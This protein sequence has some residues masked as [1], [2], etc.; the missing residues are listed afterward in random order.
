MAQKYENANFTAVM[1]EVDNASN[2]SSMVSCFNGADEVEIEELRR[3]RNVIFGD[4]AKLIAEYARVQL[5]DEDAF[6]TDSPDYDL[7]RLRWLR[8][9]V[10]YVRTAREYYE[11]GRISHD[12][13]TAAASAMT[14]IEKCWNKTKYF[15]QDNPYHVQPLPTKKDMLKPA[16]QTGE[17]RNI[18]DFSIATGTLAVIPPGKVPFPRTSSPNPPS[19]QLRV[20]EVAMQPL[21]APQQQHNVDEALQHGGKRDEAVQRWLNSTNPATPSA[22]VVPPTNIASTPTTSVGARR[23]LEA[24]RLR[25]QKE[26]E[27][28]RKERDELRQVVAKSQQQL[29]EQ[30]AV[31]EQATTA[32]VTAAANIAFEQEMAKREDADRKKAEEA[33]AALANAQIVANHAKQQADKVAHELAQ[34]EAHIQRQRA[35]L[36]QNENI[37]KLARADADMMRSNLQAAKSQAAIAKED[38]ENVRQLLGEKEKELEAER[39]VNAAQM[40]ILDAHGSMLPASTPANGHTSPKRFA[41]GPSPKKQGMHP[42]HEQLHRR[43]QSQQLPLIDLTKQTTTRSPHPTSSEKNGNN[44]QENATKTC[45]Y[46]SKSNFEYEDTFIRCKQLHVDQMRGARPS[47]PFSKGTPVDFSIH[48]KAFEKAT[49]YST[50]TDED[51]MDEMIH[52]FAGEAAKVVRL[53]QL[54]MN[55]QEAYKDVC[56]ELDS[57]FRETQDTFGTTI[58]AITR[59]KPIDS[60]DYSNHLALYTQLREAQSVVMTAGSGF[61]ANEFNRRDVIREILNA[62]LPHLTDRFWREDEKSKRTTGRSFAFQDLLNELQQWLAILRAKNPEGYEAANAKKAVIAAISSAP[63]PASTPTYAKRLVESPPK[64]QQTTKCNECGGLHETSSC[65]VL[66]AMSVEQRVE[67]LSRRGLCFHCMNPGHRASSCTQRPTCQKCSRKH[68]TMLHDRKFE[69]P[70]KKTSMSA[71][72]LP[73]QPF[74]SNA[75][76]VTTPNNAAAASDVPAQQESVL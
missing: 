14:G 20:D 17:K 35:D 2:A 25:Q 7:F 16:P 8:N 76:T 49:R 37:A 61:H 34:A 58:R 4:R 53:H 15:H 46:G 11:G 19:A 13:L 39:G 75:A 62:R 72:A 28:L 22:V 18:S 27:E 10:E 9:V 38:A 74:A 5:L 43:Q 24:S 50:L 55:H 68:A 33:K 23:M 67:A 71:A 29:Q 21:T 73:F 12:T 51:R 36:Q 54:N 64:V 31:A 63:K 41:K 3:M 59:G 44:V 65:N 40:R 47:A 6:D 69:S 70:K 56:T 57:L 66:L 60:N 32:K 45:N 42:L 48:M 1:T 52:W 30:L 26:M